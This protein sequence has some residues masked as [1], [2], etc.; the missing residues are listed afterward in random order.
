MG[1]EWVLTVL[2]RAADS[3]RS[4]VPV[5]RTF[6]LAVQES[7]STKIRLDGWRP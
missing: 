7:S 4:V 1:G 5:N 6:E 3:L 2:L